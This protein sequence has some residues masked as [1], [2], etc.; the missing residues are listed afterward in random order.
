MGKAI[1]EEMIQVVYQYSKKVYHNEIL[2]SVAMDQ[3]N[4]QSG[5]NGGSA[6]A[7]IHVF[8]KMMDGQ[9]YRRTMNVAAYFLRMIREEYGEQ[10]FYRA[11]DSVS[12]HVAYYNS[13]GNGA[14]KGIESLLNYYKPTK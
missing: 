12:K 8:G 10:Q 4:K 1:T 13:L 6:L 5:M 11:M 2:L 7:Y 9:E 3:V 14:L